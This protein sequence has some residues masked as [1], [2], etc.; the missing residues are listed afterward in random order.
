M[1]KALRLCISF[2]DLTKLVSVM[3]NEMANRMGYSYAYHSYTLIMFIP[4]FAAVE[5]GPTRSIQKKINSMIRVMCIT[6]D[7]LI[8][9]SDFVILL[10]LVYF[11]TQKFHLYKGIIYLLN[12]HTPNSA[13][14]IIPIMLLRTN[15]GM[16][17][18]RFYD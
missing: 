14:C 15:S 2:P 9:F 7:F 5:Y 4:I 16:Y 10:L 13:P 3:F 8:R 11:C 1:L 6:I 18:K 17:T 12:T